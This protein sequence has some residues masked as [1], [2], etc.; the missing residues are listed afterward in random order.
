[1]MPYK[2]WIIECLDFVK[3]IVS[4]T[5]GRKNTTEALSSRKE[6]GRQCSQARFVGLLVICDQNEEP[7][8]TMMLDPLSRWLENDQ[9][10]PFSR[11]IRS[12]EA[13]PLTQNNTW[14]KMWL[15]LIGWLDLLWLLVSFFSVEII[16]ATEWFLSDSHSVRIRQET[17]QNLIKKVKGYLSLTNSGL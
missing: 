2:V 6:L 13:D 7:A 5:W 8:A 12:Q 16:A 15:K 3:V 10:I 11:L 17:R 14:W 9:S 1:M 4:K